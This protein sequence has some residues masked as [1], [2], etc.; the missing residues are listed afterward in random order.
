MEDGL[1]LTHIEILDSDSNKPEIRLSGEIQKVAHS[2]GIESWFVSI[3]HAPAN[4][5]AFVVAE[6]FK[7]QS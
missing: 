1:A 3:T 7:T 6:G 4:S 5:L 2:L